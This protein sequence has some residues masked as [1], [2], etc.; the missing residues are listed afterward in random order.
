LFNPTLPL[1]RCE[2]TDEVTLVPEP[3]PCGSAHRLI[4]AVE[5]RLEDRFVYAGAGT[6]HADVFR[7]RLGGEA[8]VVSYQVVQTSDGADVAAVCRGPVDIAWL[9]EELVADLT[10]RGL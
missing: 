1:I 10:L 4:D 3:C 7:A 6:V 5:G 8:N 2:I 9:H